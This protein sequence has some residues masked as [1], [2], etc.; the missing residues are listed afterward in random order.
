MGQEVIDAAQQWFEGGRVALGRAGLLHG[1]GQIVLVACGQIHGDLHLCDATVLIAVH[2]VR[3]QGEQ[4]ARGKLAQGLLRIEHQV[5]QRRRWSI[6][7]PMFVGLGVFDPRA[8]ARVYHRGFVHDVE[9]VRGQVVPGCIERFVVRGEVGVGAK[10]RASSLEI[11]E[12]GPSL[13]RG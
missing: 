11:A 12:Q 6:G 7:V 13:E 9:G 5:V 2:Q 10:E 1:P 3:R 8:H 4:S